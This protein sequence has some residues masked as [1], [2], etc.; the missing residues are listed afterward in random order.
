MERVYRF[1]FQ[2][3]RNGNKVTKTF[4]MTQEGMEQMKELDKLTKQYNEDFQ[5]IFDGLCPQFDE[6]LSVIG[7]WIYTQ[8][9]IM[10]TKEEFINWFI[11]TKIGTYQMKLHFRFD[12]NGEY[13]DDIEEHREYIDWWFPDYKNTFIPNL[14]NDYLLE[15]CQEYVND[16]ELKRK[17]ILQKLLTPNQAD[18]Q[19]NGKP[20][21]PNLTL[22][23]IFEDT[24]KYVHIMGLL[25]SKGYLQ[26]NSFIWKD[27]KK[28][29]LSAV[30]NIIKN[31]GNKGFYKKEYTPLANQFCIDVAKSTFNIELKMSTA[32]KA[33]DT[34]SWIPY[35]STIP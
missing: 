22:I 1:E 8:F 14:I 26:E 7:S 10:P 24:S 19:G 11:R 16:L 6:R 17:K 20:E 32:E 31:L 25:V 5:N 2:D 12:D 34:F 27:T 4:P 35:P 21:A 13:S 29:H 23:D 18:E 33:K 15:Y 30:V 9:H 3:P 28:G